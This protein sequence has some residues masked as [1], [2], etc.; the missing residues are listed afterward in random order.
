MRMGNLKAMAPVEVVLAPCRLELTPAEP[1]DLPLGQM[2]RL[3]GFANYS[4]GHRVL[5]PSE[6]LKW[7]SQEKSVPGLE[8]YDNREAVGAVGAVAA[9]AGP[10]NVYA[11]YHGQESNRVTFKSVAADPNVKLD[12]DVDRTLRIA[13]ELG[14][15]VLTASGPSGDVELVPSL[16]SF[17]SSNDKVLKVAE[18][19]G[20][21][22]TGDPG[23]VMLTGSHLAAKEPAK[24]E[25]H[26]CDPAKMKL[27]FDPASVR[28]LVNQK[29]AMP[30]FLLEMEEGGTKE[31]QRAELAGQGVGYYVEKPQAV[32]FHPPILT[33]LS[34]ATPFD[35]S[36]SIPV[37]RPALA[38]VEVVDAPSKALRISPSAASPL[39]PGQPVALTVE[40]QVGDD[41]PSPSGRGAGSEGWQEVRPDAV[42]WNVPAQAQIIWTP[43]TQNLRPRSRSFRT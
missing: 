20:L 40:Q 11:T 19:T 22:A 7:F 30:L 9:G 41:S 17:K 26:V 18:K 24:K 14:R 6:R 10:L 13:G 23:N 43:P 2:L 34:P 32:R 29:A 4:G 21:F 33:G 12:I 8:L 31:K 39:A 38:K 3:Q 1:V 42:N 25:F 37:L 35:I 28:V 15:V 16:T 36:G 27:A 5:I